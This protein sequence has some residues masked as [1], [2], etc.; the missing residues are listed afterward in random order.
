VRYFDHLSGFGDSF[1]GLLPNLF[2]EVVPSRERA[3][4]CVDLIDTPGLVD[5]DMKVRKQ[6]AVA[7]DTAR[8]VHA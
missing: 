1:Q 8:L 2:T 6:P 3:F 7:L 5:G 4:A